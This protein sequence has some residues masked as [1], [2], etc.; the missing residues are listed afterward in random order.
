MGKKIAVGV[1]AAVV[2]L[3]GGIA[4]AGSAAEDRKAERA[5]Q[6][7]TWKLD[8]QLDGIDATDAQRKTVHG[9]KDQ[10]F[11]EGLKMRATKE[12]VRT[13]LVEQWKAPRPDANAVHALVDRMMDEV[14]AFAH[15]AADAGITLHQ[16]LSAEQRQEVLQKVEARRSRWSH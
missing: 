11:E 7:V 16:T 12:Q 4:Y 9:L 15:K 10:L 14:R 2:A 6:Y 8:D 5:K 1:T 3:V 13:G